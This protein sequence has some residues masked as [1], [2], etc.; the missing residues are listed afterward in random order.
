MLLATTLHV[1]MFG[2]PSVVAAAVAQ[3]Q[4][5]RCGSCLCVHLCYA[6]V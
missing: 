6:G 5:V 2:W 3:A 1:G 4:P